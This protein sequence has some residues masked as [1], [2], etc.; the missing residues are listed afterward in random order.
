VSDRP[1]VSYGFDSLMGL[2]LRNK[3]QTALELEL[4]M[5]DIL[6]NARCD[7][8]AALLARRLDADAHP[9]TAAPGSWV[10]VPRPAP[11]AR[12]RLV[13][14]PYAGGAAH[15]FSSWPDELPAEVE[16]CAI[17]PPGR[18]ERLHEPLPES[19]EEMV[20]A[21]VPALVPYLDKPFAVYGHCLGAIVMLEVLR[22][23]AA[24]HG[25]RPV[26]VFVAAAPAP[27]KYAVPNVTMR[28]SGDLSQ[29]LAFIGFMRDGVLG[30][31]DAERHL[32]PAVKRDLEIAARYRHVPGGPLD[33]PLTALA[34]RE[35]TFA[36]PHVVA[37]W[38]A[39]TTGPA[40]EIVFA[41]EHYFIVPERRA[42]LA[43]VAAELLLRLAALEQQQGATR[44]RML[45]TP[46]P[47]VGPRA[48][49]FCFPG[50]GQSTS[51]YDAWPSAL[52]EDVEV[53]LLDL[54]GRG[55]RARELPLGRVDEIVDHVVL[56]I[57]GRLDAPF[58]FF[59]IDI[60]ALIHFETTRRLRRDGRPLPTHLFV[61]AAMA[62]QEYFWAPMHHMPSERLFHGLRTLGFSVDDRDSTE[63]ALRA[64]CAAMASYVY[65]DEPPLEMPVTTFWGERDSISPPGSVKSWR[66]QTRGP[67]TFRVWSGSH[68]LK[69]DGVSGLIDAVRDTLSRFW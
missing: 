24:R 59:G 16:V 1:F 35:D 56:A 28:S 57:S 14:F 53:C 44:A 48:R 51:V 62:P 46:A 25:L 52:G 29:L 43:V 61:A 18:H 15:L 32:M 49:L 55:A 26:H 42:V 9:V 40:S 38:L 65:V 21:I 11:D 66:E 68:D 63:R 39:E 67:F 10:V 45:R 34:G 20:A 37:E 13:C 3:L 31:A 54:P 8:L 5:A 19:I 36:P 69:S 22:E 60:G 2:E 30:D 7:A 47:R 17:Q 27:R 50:L 23:L 12:L 33:A 6:T 4:S 64:E 58:A 41:G